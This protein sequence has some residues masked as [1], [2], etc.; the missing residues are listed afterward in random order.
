MPD[1]VLTA[2][3]EGRI[4]DANPAAQS[5]LEED[6][7][8][9]SVSAVFADCPTLLDHY[10]A[11]EERTTDVQLLDDGHVRHFSATTTPIV[12]QGQRTG[13]VIVLRDVTALK[14]REQ[15]L[16]RHKQ[17]Y[18][19]IVRHNLRNELT[20]I[21]GNA[22]EIS[23]RSDD[24]LSEFAETIRDRC[25][26]LVETSEKARHIMQIIESDG[27]LLTMAGR[28]LADTVTAEMAEQYPAASVE[29]SG[30]AEAWVSA[31]E[32]L[33]VAVRNLVENAIVHND[34]AGTVEVSV[35]RAD[36]TVEIVVADDGPG[37][38]EHEIAVLDRLTETALEH[39]NGAGLWLVNWIVTKSGGD[40]DFTVT[41]RGT[42]VTVSLQAATVR[43]GDAPK[44]RV[45]H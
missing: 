30:A 22:E 3:V 37:I 23:R 40:L 33:D 17:V 19:R 25:D 9:K 44:T 6:P 13:T 8:R 15:D 26:E 2:D 14:S 21:R 24:R 28:T 41:D 29:T 39:S 20:I 45:A 1:A 32:D 11:D 4:V 38:P 27:D 5:L 16:D 18:N 34:G 42:T 35:R 7:I 36:E 12:E 43:D 10:R 31:H